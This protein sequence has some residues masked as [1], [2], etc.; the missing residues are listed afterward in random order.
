MGALVADGYVPHVQDQVNARFTPGDALKEMIGFQTE[1]K[2]F[3][4][5][6]SLRSSMTLLNVAPALEKDRKGFLTY[7]DKLK[8]VASQVDG[9]PSPKNG[10]DQIRA[11]LQENLESPRPK[12]VY[13]TYHPSGSRGRTVLVTTSDSPLSFSA[14]EYLTISV[15]AIQAAPKG[16]K[17]SSRKG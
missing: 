13:F 3:S 6:H 4:P 11:S 16:K 10:H 2:L 17:P 9:Q 8:D 14:T 1:F 5:D 15:P 12:P 7:V